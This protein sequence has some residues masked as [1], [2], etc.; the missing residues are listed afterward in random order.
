M[1]FNPKLFVTRDPG[2]QELPVVGIKFLLRDLFNDRSEV[3]QRGYG[4][5]NGWVIAPG[6]VLPRTPEE[7]RLPDPVKRNGSI[8]P[9]PGQDFIGGREGR[10]N[11]GAFLQHGSYFGD[12][13]VSIVIWL[14]FSLAFIRPVWRRDL[15]RPPRARTVAETIPG[16]AGLLH[17]D[18]ILSDCAVRFLEIP[19][20]LDLSCVQHPGRTL[21]IQTDMHEDLEGS[22][23]E[24]L[25]GQVHFHTGGEP[26]AGV[27]QPHRRRAHA[28]SFPDC[29]SAFN[30]RLTG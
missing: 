17:L 18:Q 26:V 30:P 20:Q 14:I 28:S 16:D 21:G 2:A 23:G 11:T 7:D 25:K 3:A 6:N 4:A 13:P 8:E 1:L 12:E 15:N 29:D 27:F 9:L 22:I 19:R 10:M 5:L 24:S